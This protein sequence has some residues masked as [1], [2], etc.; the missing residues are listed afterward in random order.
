MGITQIICT[1]L[2]LTVAVSI[3]TLAS[4]FAYGAAKTRVPFTHVLVINFVGSLF[5]GISL[6]LGYA[7]RFLP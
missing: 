3:D 2:L 1:A 4:G 5:L 6:F 7:K